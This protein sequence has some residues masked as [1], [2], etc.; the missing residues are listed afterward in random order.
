M[1]NRLQAKK[2]K[3]GVPFPDDPLFEA[4][5]KD[6]LAEMRQILST[7]TGDANCVTWRYQLGAQCSVKSHEAFTLL[8][9]SGLLVDEKT[10]VDFMTNVDESDFSCEILQRMIDLGAPVNG[11]IDVPADAHLKRWPIFEILQYGAVQYLEILLKNGADPNKPLEP[12]NQTPLHFLA[13]LWGEDCCR[14]TSSAHSLAL[15]RQEGEIL[16]RYG[17]N[18]H[19]RDR[20]GMTPIL[21]AAERLRAPAIEFLAD[22][23][24]SLL[25]LDSRGLGIMTI[26]NLAREKKYQ[27]EATYPEVAATYERCMARHCFVDSESGEI[28]RREE[29]T[30]P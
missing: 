30:N 2:Y 28:L 8:V 20:S 29:R 6:D 18:V 25:D 22:H 5:K 17:A 23:G 9:E 12:I 19:A 10:L 13:K 7:G 27:G 4:V 26:A 15:Y 11:H 3:T 1:V 21:C 14:A 24:A 16:L